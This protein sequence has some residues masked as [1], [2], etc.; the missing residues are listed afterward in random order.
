MRADVFSRR[1]VFRMMLFMPVVGR[2]FGDE[3]A[4]DS[5]KARKAEKK[6]AGTNSRKQVADAGS[7]YS[8]AKS[9]TDSP[10]NKDKGKDSDEVGGTRAPGKPA[11]TA[12]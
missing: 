7:V 10:K 2:L 1:T 8:Q 6:P 9:E 12:K 11:G 4:A 3:K 5:G